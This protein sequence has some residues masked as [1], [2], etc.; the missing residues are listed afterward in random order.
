VVNLSAADEA[1]PSPGHP[2]RP[3]MVRMRPILGRLWR[4]LVYQLGSLPASILAFTVIVAGVSVAA[5]AIG[6]I[7]GLPLLLAIFAIVRWNAK[8]ERKR[9]AYTLGAPIPEAY[10]RRTGNW[11]RRLRI[12]S[13]DPQSW[14]DLAWLTFMGTVGF[15]ASVAMITMWGVVLGMLVLPA[16]YWSLPHNGVDFGLFRADTL[17]EAF[18][19]TDVAL[20][21]LPVAY[22][23]QRWITEGMVRL[24]AAL[25][26]PSREAA[27]SARVEEL[28]ATR[29]GAVDAAAAEL[30][31]IER[32]LHDGAQARL[33][34]LAMDLGMAEERFARDPGGALELVGEAR[35][36]AKRALA[37]LRDLARGIRPSMLAERGLGPALTELAGRSPIPAGVDLDVP[38]KL[39]AAIEN[40]TWFVVSEA[41]ANV[42]KHSEAKHVLVAVGK[43]DGLVTVEVTDDGKGGANAGGSGLLG[44][45][46]RVAALDGTLAVESPAGGP[47]TIR[48][49]LPCAS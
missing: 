41:L 38:D 22:L 48:A 29:A 35:E 4:D 39:P 5:T 33:V 18:L 14:K 8:L 11:L 49:E 42:A 37:E 46:R 3:I 27:L 44:L 47:T 32:D 16:W 34:A 25:L 21:A 28:A 26:R 17:G 19:A 31:R 36:E 20:I 12:V 40:A 45:R 1:T 24:G 6:I 13:T 30:Q 23:L 7:I 43:V 10:R 9:T 15:A 2:P